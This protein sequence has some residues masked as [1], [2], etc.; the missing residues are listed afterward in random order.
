MRMKLT[1]LGTGTSHGVPMIGCSCRTCLS[2][3]PK[4]KR[5]NACLHIAL[6]NRSILIDCGRDFR[7]QALRERLPGVDYVLLTH[8]HFDHVA[9]IDDLRVYTYHREEPIPVLGMA[10]HLQY[11][12]TYI[13]HYLFDETIQKGGGV[14]RL[15]L[16][17]IQERFSLD[18]LMFEPLRAF[19]GE[20]PVL[21]YKFAKCAYLCD[22]S[23]VPPATLQKLYGLDLLIL[24]ALRHEPHP[25]HLSLGEALE[26]VAELEPRRTFLTHM[27]HDV[28]HEEVEAELALL[29]GRYHVKTEVH[30]AY[31]GLALEL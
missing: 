19:H 29:G 24:N 1:F 28:L 9:G 20:L 18:G 4:D 13:Y 30:L 15:S 5:T 26:L 3:N 2:E 27:S 25:T 22:V 31:D 17:A 8:T 14:A 6:G 16:I 12:K 23:R 7:Q 21:G 11:L 10:E